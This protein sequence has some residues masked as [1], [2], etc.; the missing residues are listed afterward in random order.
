MIL[1]LDVSTSITGATVIDRDGEILYCE[2]WDTRNKKKYPTLYE[3]ADFAKEKLRSLA[4]RS[5]IIEKVYIE[6]NLQMFAAGRSSANTL[7][8]IAK[9]NGIV[10]YICESVL[11]TKVEY[12]SPGSARKTC[13]IKVS[14]GEKA[15]EVVLKHLME[16]E[17]D[18][19]V[20][21]TKFG[22]PAPGTYDRADSVIVA[23]A[24]LEL[25]RNENLKF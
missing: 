6:K 8:T 1:G 13:N 11:K 10:S 20:K 18:F 14:R 22:N 3:K 5:F 19:E 23:R 17:R 2:A 7:F 9:F 21:Y 24:G 15:K 16:N 25:W 4:H 12:I